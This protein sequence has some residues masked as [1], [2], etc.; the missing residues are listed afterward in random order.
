[1]DVEVLD[2]ELR[3]LIPLC[4]MIRYVVSV[5]DDGRLAIL[6]ACGSIK[7]EAVEPDTSLI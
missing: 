4:R 7:I 5:V 1:M 3:G 6:R 2:V